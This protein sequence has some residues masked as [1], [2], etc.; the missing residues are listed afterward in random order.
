MTYLQVALDYT[1][2]TKAL[3]TAL[4]IVRAV[5]DERVW[6]EAGTPLIKSWGFISLRLLKEATNMFVVADTKTIDAAEL[7]I[8]EAYKNNAD[9]A[10]VLGLSDE[11]TIKTSIGLARSH[12][13]KLIVDLIGVVNTYERAVQAFEMG[14]DY[15]L[16]HIGVDVQ[17]ARGLTAV[18]LLREAYKF[19]KDTGGRYC[20]AGG[21]KLQ[22]VEK[23]LEAEP[24][25]IVVGAAITRAS[26]PAKVVSD[27]LE[28]LK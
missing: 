26:D 16:F 20:I 5:R 17:R 28:K 18:E 23:I 22:D 9:A 6:I 13:R 19:K 7:E 8:G 14:A 1:S 25:V 15:V 24:D 10:T 27:F 3:E 2:L 21:I 4:S 11:S 12:G